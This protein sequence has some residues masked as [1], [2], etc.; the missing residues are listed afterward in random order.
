MYT[1]TQRTYAYVYIHTDFT[2]KSVHVHLCMYAASTYVNTDVYTYTFLH[3]NTRTRLWDHA[4]MQEFITTI[5]IDMHV[6]KFLCLHVDVHRHKQTFAKCACVSLILRHARMFLCAGIC[7]IYPSMY[8][9]KGSVSPCMHVR[10][11]VC[12][13]H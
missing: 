2:R 3:M 11:Y 9:C 8:T 13:K 10:M 5:H 4:Y 12:F 1:C 7:P 6:C